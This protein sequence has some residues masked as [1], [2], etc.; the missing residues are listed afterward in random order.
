MAVFSVVSEVLGCSALEWEA[1]PLAAF[2][3]PDDRK[4]DLARA[5]Y[6]LYGPRFAQHPR[7]QNL[8]DHNGISRQDFL[9]GLEEAQAFESG[10]FVKLHQSTLRKVD[11]IADIAQRVVEGR[12]RTQAR[13][14]DR[15]GPYPEAAIESVKNHWVVSL[16]GL[17]V[18]FAGI[19]GYGWKIAG[20]FEGQAAA[21]PAPPA[22][23]TTA[24][25]R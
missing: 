22:A 6:T 25:Q 8:V 18:L 4:F 10:E 19:L 3:V 11:L 12:L 15:I 9:T 16:L 14:W 21:A 2:V 7:L 20:W 1:S 17:L 24:S 23:V 13:L 5:L